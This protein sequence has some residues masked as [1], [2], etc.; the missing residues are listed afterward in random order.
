M[1]SYPFELDAML[2]QTEYRKHC[3][4]QRKIKVTEMCAPIDKIRRMSANDLLEFCGQSNV[5]P[6]NLNAILTKV[7]IS[8][9]PRDFSDLE[10]VLR[11]T[12]ACQSEVQVLGAIVMSGNS[13]AIF[14]NQ[15]DARDSHRCRFTIAHELAHC[16]LAHQCLVNGA[17]VD[18]RTQGLPLTEEEKAA[19]VFAGELLIPYDMLLNVMKKLLI[20]SVH[21]L[22]T[23]FD[24]SDNVMLKRLEHLNMDRKILGYNY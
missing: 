11:A 17:H 10:Q 2:S 19:N 8:A 1:R 7:G 22:A 14:Y 16:C 23:I 6:V 3:A 15:Q 13:A 4:L 24:V 18:F 9:L 21:T 20:P 12:K 5:V